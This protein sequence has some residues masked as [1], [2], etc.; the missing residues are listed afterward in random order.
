MFFAPISRRMSLC[1]A[2]HYEAC[3]VGPRPSSLHG[4]EVGWTGFGGAVVLQSNR[5]SGSYQRGDGGGCEGRR[6]KKKRN[7]KRRWMGEQETVMGR[8]DKGE[9]DKANCSSLFCYVTLTWRQNLAGEG[10]RNLKC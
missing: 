9:E 7:K 5:T 8:S 3:L 2:K 10:E 6:L 4:R 1:V